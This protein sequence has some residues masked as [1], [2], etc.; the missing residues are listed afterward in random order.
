MPEIHQYLESF[1][2]IRVAQVHKGK[3]PSFVA[4]FNKDYI[5]VY[6]PTDSQFCKLN[7][8]HIFPD[9]VLRDSKQVFILGENLYLDFL[10]TS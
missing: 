8:S 9:V 7:S 1:E 10:Y 5:K 3:T 4:P 2:G 6:E